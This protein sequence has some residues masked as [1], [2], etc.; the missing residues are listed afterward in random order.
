[1]MGASIMRAHADH[2]FRMIVPDFSERYA[3]PTKQSGF[4]DGCVVQYSL[5]PTH[6]G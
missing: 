2:L 4:D 5:Q 3:A 6:P 1:M